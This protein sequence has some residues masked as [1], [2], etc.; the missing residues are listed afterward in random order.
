MLIVVVADVEA[1]ITLLNDSNRV[2]DFVLQL[3]EADLLQTI[4]HQ[5]LCQ[6]HYGLL[7]S[8]HFAQVE[9]VQVYAVQIYFI[10]ICCVALIGVTCVL[11]MLRR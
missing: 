4:S 9:Y 11:G 6:R 2:I 7:I 3:I 5:S 10:Q 8:I 1:S